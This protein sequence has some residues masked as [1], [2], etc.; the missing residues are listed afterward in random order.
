MKTVFQLK[1]MIFAVALLG[2]AFT[3]CKEDKEDTKADKTNQL[4]DK[5]WKATAIT[6]DP[7]IDLFGTGTPITNIYAQLP[8]C[9]KDDLT[10]FRKNGTVA[11]DEGGSK[12]SNN[13]PQTVSGLW[14]FNTDQTVISITQ[15]GETESW[16]ILEFTND[17][18]KVEF[19]VDDD[20][21]GLTYTITSIY[22]K[23]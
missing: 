10:V 11:F 12:C 22:A 5:Q 9:S 4:V 7:A 1:T 23:Q 16:K 2:I 8:A 15:D 21:S 6:V 18:I 14:S 20:E 3:G 17:R 19:T 13:D